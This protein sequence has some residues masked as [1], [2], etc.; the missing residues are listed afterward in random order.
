MY[1]YRAK[2]D[3]VVD[4]DTIAVTLQLGFD[5]TVEQK[6]RLLGI[7]A[8]ETRGKG[9]VKGIAAKAFLSGLIG[10]KQIMIRTEKDKRGS[11]GRYLAT[12]Y[13]IADGEMINVN[14]LLVEEGHAVYKDY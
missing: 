13:L 10:G 4:G 3:R 6:L 14:A 1:T 7:N 2:V 5:V 9:K 12:V 8:P 11:F